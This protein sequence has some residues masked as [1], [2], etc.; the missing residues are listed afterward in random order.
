MFQFSNFVVSFSIL[1]FYNCCNLY[2]RF[3]TIVFQ[4]IRRL[5]NSFSSKLFTQKLDFCLVFAGWASWH[6]GH[7]EGSILNSFSYDAISISVSHIP[8]S[9]SNIL[10]TVR[11]VRAHFNRLLN[12][13]CVTQEESRHQFS[14][15]QEADVRKYCLRIHKIQ[16]ATAWANFSSGQSITEQLKSEETS[17]GSAWNSISC[18]IRPGC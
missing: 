2:F 10:L 12:C 1:N 14:V 18:V 17:A 7:A 15:W 3:K 16:W 8:E 13:A 4:N 9:L 6:T 11:P 5:Y